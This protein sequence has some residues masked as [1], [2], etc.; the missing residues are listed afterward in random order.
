MLNLL[1]TGALVAFAPS[2]ASDGVPPP[3]V[4]VACTGAEQRVA[5]T[6]RRARLD[7]TL[8]PES[9]TSE[10][11]AFGPEVLRACLDTLERERVA[12]VVPG[13]R[14]Q[15]LS[16]PQR[17]V[18][19][20]VLA[21][22]PREQVLHAALERTELSHEAAAR[23]LVL[24]VLGVAGS[25]EHLPLL[26]ELAQLEREESPPRAVAQAF[27]GALVGI[28]AREPRAYD[29]LANYHRDA[30]PALTESIV[31]AVGDAGDARGLQ[32]LEHVITF[33]PEELSLCASQVRR[34]GRSGDPELDQG[35]AQR[36]RWAVDPQRPETCRALLLALGELRDYE[37]VPLLIELMQ[38]PDAGLSGN[39]LWALRRITELEFPAL[40]ERW[41]A[42]YESELEWFAREEPLA[43]RDLH[44]GAPSAAAAAARAISERRLWREELAQ[45]LATALQR[46]HPT[47]RAPICRALERLGVDS[48]AVELVELLDDDDSE[49]ARAA[50]RALV[51]LTGHELPA[52]S[53]TWRLA[54][55]RDS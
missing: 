40:P 13:D 3:G 52:D 30:P 45:E 1:A 42:W 15:K 20:Q 26:L 17:E 37:S 33:R 4:L 8:A 25:V 53:V 21:G 32:F 46:P 39:A 9:L 14:E 38:S 51:A 12:Q 27:Q 22:L 50:W 48:V 54:L 35:L 43:L 7:R 36:L 6:L 2:L 55:A 23:R 47:L 16:E 11:A 19:L 49:S 29:A 18:L 28:L 24:D 31:R 34:V 44:H 10:I 41:L 5:S